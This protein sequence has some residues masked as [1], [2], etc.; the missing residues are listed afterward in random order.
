MKPGPITR[1][2]YFHLA[3]LTLL[4]INNLI[5]WDFNRAVFTA[6][7]RFAELGVVAFYLSIIAPVIV[8]LLLWVLV[9]WR[10]SRI[11]RGGIVAYAVLWALGVAGVAGGGNL[12]LL[13]V[14]LTVTSLLLQV[15]A[16]YF[17]HRPSA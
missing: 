1:F 14:T 6:D 4:L 2:S 17:L 8:P 7:P 11:A 12:P 15:I 13:M 10:R 5:H 9:I 16:I 3:S